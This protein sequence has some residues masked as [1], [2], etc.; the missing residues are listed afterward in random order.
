LSSKKSSKH[1]VGLNEDKIT[2]DE[3]KVR[4]MKKKDVVDGEE[5]RH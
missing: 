1:Y 3:Y 4:F 2:L 5:E